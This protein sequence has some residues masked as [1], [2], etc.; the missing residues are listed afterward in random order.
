MTRQTL[1]ILLSILIS[2]TAIGQNYQVQPFSN[3]PARPNTTINKTFNNSNQ[4]NPSGTNEHVGNK[5]LQHSVTE[6]LLER[7][8]EYRQG[9]ESAR[10]MTNQIIRDIDS[11]ERSAPPVYTIPVVFHVIHKGEAVGVSRVGV[12]SVVSIAWSACLKANPKQNKNKIAPDKLQTVLS[13]QF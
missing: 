7:N 1:S 13:D 11:G 12:C 6:E 2:A 9:V 8:A 10:Q 3:A 5:C 4:V